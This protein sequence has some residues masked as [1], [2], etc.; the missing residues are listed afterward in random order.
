M[1]GFAIRFLMNELL[2]D[3]KFYIGHK[4]SDKL[5]GYCKLDFSLVFTKP[6]PYLHNN[7]NMRV[8]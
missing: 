8:P 2:N 3:S 4:N 5:Y 7:E 1:V 6:I